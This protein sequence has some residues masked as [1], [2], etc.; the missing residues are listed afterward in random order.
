MLVPANFVFRNALE[1]KELV[2][3]LDEA[4]L[5]E[6]APTQRPQRHKL[7]QR[8]LLH[9]TVR[10]LPLQLVR[11]LLKIAAFCIALRALSSCP[12]DVFA[13]DCLRFD[14]LEGGRQ[15]Q[16]ATRERIFFTLL[17]VIAQVLHL[18]ELSVFG[19]RRR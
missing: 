7:V 8:V 11:Q 1:S 17:S 15:L 9:A 6:R 3:V 14:E 18:D 4:D 19:L 2:A 16:I 13:R 10:N 12:S 5:A